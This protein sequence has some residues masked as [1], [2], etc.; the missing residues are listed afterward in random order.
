MRIL[1][2]P[3]LR[4]FHRSVRE[5]SILCRSS[6]LKIE[7]AKTERRRRAGAFAELEKV[8]LAAKKTAKTSAGSG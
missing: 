2:A 8:A 3:Y 6:S 7:F 5:G 4:H 1:F